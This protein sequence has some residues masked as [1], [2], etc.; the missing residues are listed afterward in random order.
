MGLFSKTSDPDPVLIV[1]GIEVVFHRDHD[2]WEFEYGETEFWAAGTTFRLPPRAELD[3][4][5]DTVEALKPQIISRLANGLNEWGDAK[6]NDGESYCVDL[7]D[8]ATERTFILS[9]SDGASW[10][11]LAVDFIIRERHIIDVSWGD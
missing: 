8:F 5:L 10:G 7:R 9:W 1:D 3:E 6:L 11:D 4:I 2:W